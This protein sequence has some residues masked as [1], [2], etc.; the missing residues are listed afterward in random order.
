MAAV[1]WLIRHPQPLIV[2]ALLSLVGWGLSD[3]ARHVGAFTI[4]RVQLPA[5]ASLKLREP[6]VGKNIWQVD[7]HA[8]ASELKRQQPWLK[9]VRVVRQLPNAIRID[10]IPRFPIAQVRADAWYPMDG[11]GFILP[12][13][14]SAPDG[15][16]VRLVGF[17]RAGVALRVGK[18]HPDARVQLAL[19]VMRRL[20]RAR[21]LVSRRLTE[22]NV[23]DPQQLRFVLDG[24]IE[25]RC[26]SE[27][28][29]EAHL[30]RLQAAF[31]AMARHPVTAGYIDVRF[32]EPVV[33]P[34]VG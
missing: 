22:L 8:L 2:V 7:I 1:S 9:D 26:G 4:E 25:I 12:Q 3:Y 10:P 29:L 11:E 13:G 24:A 20:Q 6:L 34:R 19:R 23:A 15:R 28:E 5:D 21:P 30:E 17:D 32:Q 16:L 31:K 18:E 14:R 27:G 33:S